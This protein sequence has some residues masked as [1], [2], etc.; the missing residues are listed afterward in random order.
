[1][2]L[3]GAA[4]AEA[5]GSLRRLPG[6]RRRLTRS[7]ASPNAPDVRRLVIELRNAFT[8]TRSADGSRVRLPIA[9]MLQDTFRSNPLRMVHPHKP[10][11]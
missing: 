6:C 7:E 10:F 9:P 5:L 4:F 8:C 3:T 2:K 11:P 1:M